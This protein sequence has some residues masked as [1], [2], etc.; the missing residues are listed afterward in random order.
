M[1][2]DTAPLRI[3]IRVDAAGDPTGTTLWFCSERCQDPSP[4]WGWVEKDADTPV[5]P[6]TSCHRCDVVLS[7]EYL[8][9]PPVGS[10]FHGHVVIATCWEND[11]GEGGENQDL[12]LAGMLLMAPSSPYYRVVQTVARSGDIE[13][14]EVNTMGRYYNV[15]HAAAAYLEETGCV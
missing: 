7:P 3:S 5:P 12:F 6:T 14:A 1:T 4:S 13:W 10:T 9:L 8:D 15:V 2:N 11:C